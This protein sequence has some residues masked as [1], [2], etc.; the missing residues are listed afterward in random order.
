LEL[1]ET[2]CEIAENVDNALH[3]VGQAEFPQGGP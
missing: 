3:C 1:E 2:L